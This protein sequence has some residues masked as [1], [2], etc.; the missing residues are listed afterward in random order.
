MFAPGNHPVIEFFEYRVEASCGVSR[1]VDGAAQ[2]WRAA[3]R[4]LSL[5]ALKITALR[6]RRVHSGK[7]LE[8]LGGPKRF[9]SPI[10]PRI[11]EPSVTLMPGMV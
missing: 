2:V 10:S 11:A 1:Q 8:L 7:G 5:G 3:F 6:H 4:H 9:T